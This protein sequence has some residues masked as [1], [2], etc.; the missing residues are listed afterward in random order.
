MP[1]LKYLKYMLREFKNVFEFYLIPFLAV[2]FPNKIFYP[3]FKFVCRYTF[4]YN[5]Y[6]QNSYSEA[7]KVIKVSQEKKT[8]D[9]HVKLLFLIDITDFW[10]ARFRPKKM[11][12]LLNRSGNW[13]TDNGHMAMSL[14]WGSGYITLLDLKQHNL[15]P[16]FVYSETPV[17]FKFQSFIERQYRKARTKHI[18]NISGS[19]AIATGGGYDRIKNIVSNDG[20][21]ILLFDAPQY[22]KETHYQ[23]TVFNQKYNIAKGFVRL[24]CTEKINYQLYSVKLN[25]ASG[26]RE[27]SIKQLNNTQSEENLIKELSLFFEELLTSSPEQWFFWRQSSGLFMENSNE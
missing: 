21:P 13:H 23:L 20:V 8:W 27:I 25:Y 14:H 5:K 4:L 2:I 16:Y 12:K 9:T 17:E 22:N 7:K 26:S 1:D 10:L 3:I 15:D 18:N 19:M 11:L 24:I 6:S